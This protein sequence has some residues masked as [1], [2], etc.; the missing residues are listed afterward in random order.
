MKKVTYIFLF[1]FLI[2]LLCTKAQNTSVNDSIAIFINNSQP[3]QVVKTIN[4]SAF[5]F[6]KAKK[7]CINFGIVGNDYHYIILKLSA[8]YILEGQ[9]L[10]IDN[11]S[12]DTVNIYKIYNDK[13][14]H[15]LYNGGALVDFNNGNYVWHT[16]PVDISNNPS[17]YLIAIKAAQKNINVTYE[18]IHKDAL[19]KKYQ[20]HDR[21]IFFYIGIICLI[22]AI[23]GFALLLFK[24]SV[25][26]AYLGYIICISGWIVSHYGYIFPYLYPHVPVINEIAKPVS[27]LGA[28]FFLLLVLNIVFKKH[29]QSRPGLQQLVKCMLYALPILTMLIL[30]LLVPNIDSFVKN[31]LMIVWHTGLL[32]SICTI[33]YTPLVFI[34]HDATA[35]IFSLAMV[36]ICMMTIV[37][38]FANSGYINNYF[39]GEHGVT[40]GSLL[41]NCI[42]A[43]GLF[44]SLLEENKNNHKQIHDLEQEQTETLKKLIT[45]QDNERTRI[46]GDLH[47][48]IGP[49]LAA[50]KINVRRII[51]AKD[52][53]QQAE[54]EEK[55]ESMIDDSINEIRNVAHNLMPKSLSSKG[56]INTLTDYFAGL[57]QLYKKTIVFNHQIQSIFNPDLQINIYRIICELALNAAKHSN[58]KLIT[59]CIKADEKLVSVNIHDDGQGFHTKNED[60]NNSLG[61]QNAQSR[62]L[63]LKGK[64][65]LKTENG[66]GTDINM[67]I[68]LQFDKAKINGF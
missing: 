26:A 52:G 11:T 32:L 5:H 23:I 51:I 44:Y 50:L 19:Q 29:L 45:V 67:E 24:T 39:I 47:D 10:L 27:S 65:N 15:L 7:N 57:E 38:L 9:C 60:H 54:L 53:H 8:A 2:I 22:I 59:V 62:V 64:F 36:V 46:A 20:H 18:I 41:E 68:P 28:G 40:L 30:V 48:N 13:R 42:M 49:L 56:L 61:L 34:R 66:K 55:T 1:H 25:F 6:R 63:Y 31:A 16:V 35:K 43:F 17:F 37:Q 21:V 14:S 4:P 33:I 12:L 58:A 3:D